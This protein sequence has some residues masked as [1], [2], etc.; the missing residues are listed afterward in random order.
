LESGRLVR[1][2]ELTVLLHPQLSEERGQ[3][4]DGPLVHVLASLERLHHPELVFHNLHLD[5]AAEFR[6]EGGG[7]GR[8]L[9]LLK[10][11]LANIFDL[12]IFLAQLGF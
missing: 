6:D 9:Q 7:G 10:A 1:V 8:D 12:L 11:L 4:V 3:L 5:H 2:E